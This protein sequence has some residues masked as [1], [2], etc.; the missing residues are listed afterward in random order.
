MTLDTVALETPAIFAIRLIFIRSSEACSSCRPV[1]YQPAGFLE[2]LRAGQIQEMRSRAGLPSILRG[3]GLSCARINVPG[4]MDGI[5]PGE[6][7]RLE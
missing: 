2:N 3:A 1:D 5:A 6:G 4:N 7:S